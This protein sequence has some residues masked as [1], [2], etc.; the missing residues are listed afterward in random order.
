M[1]NQTIEQA[2]G[3][4]VS[5]VETVEFLHGVPVNLPSQYKA[6]LRGVA[7]EALQAQRDAGAREEKKSIYHTVNY[8]KKVLLQAQ[9]AELERGLRTYASLTK[10]SYE[11]SNNF[12]WNL[13]IQDQIDST[14]AL[15]KE[16]S[17]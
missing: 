8:E 12:F 3:E 10:G 17:E 16:L 15:I 5:T 4:I 7:R 2:V 1:K 6:D 14:D 9:R 13:A 11:A